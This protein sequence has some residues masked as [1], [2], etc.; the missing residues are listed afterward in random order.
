MTN[1]LEELKSINQTILLKDMIER[2]KACGLIWNKI[3]IN[4][5]QIRIS[6]YEFNLSKSSNNVILDVTRK[7]TLYRSYN[8]YNL[9]EVEDLFNI[10]EKLFW[11]YDK[12]ETLEDLVSGLGELEGCEFDVITDVGSG[13]L[14]AGG[15]AIYGMLEDIEITLL[16]TSITFEPTLFPWNGIVGSI[17]DSPNANS[18]DGDG[19][20]IR[21]Q[22]AGPLPTN[23][24]YATCEFDMTNLPQAP[25]FSFD[26]S[27]AH[28]R[29][30]ELGVI[31]T[32]DVLINSTLHYT[33]QVVSTSSYTV[34]SSG[35]TPLPDVNT[36]DEL[37]V[38]LSMF[39]N[40]GNSLPRAIRISAVDI[41]IYGY[42][43]V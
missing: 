9:P 13:G 14:E 35:K 21:Q 3:N 28:R 36:I 2:T 41:K 4:L 20:Y 33:G 7:G 5:Y 39:T 11:N 8:S 26:V 16:P 19:S 1:N 27:V 38:R 17:D 25:L 34:F 40:T 22:V 31:L 10:V 29:E 37:Q 15:E 42:Q 30:V 32:V 24:G 23:W 6:I 12:T 18:N 43:V